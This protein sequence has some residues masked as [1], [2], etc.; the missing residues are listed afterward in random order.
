MIL[1]SNK[2]D[3]QNLKL[4]LQSEREFVLNRRSL[5]NFT[6]V[7]GLG[8]IRDRS[9]FFLHYIDVCNVGFRQ[10]DGFDTFER[11]FFWAFLSP[12]VAMA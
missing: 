5:G 4:G 9:G 12:E 3:C 1:N 11:R 8:I 7:E 6:K 10:I 2:N